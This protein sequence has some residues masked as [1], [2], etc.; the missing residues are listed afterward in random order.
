MKTS[1]NELIERLVNLSNAN[2]LN[3]KKSDCDIIDKIKDIVRNEFLEKEKKQIIDAFTKGNREEFYDG[4][5][6]LGFNYFN[7]TFKQ[8]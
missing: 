1:C 4:S 5:E 6:E 8:E 7:E 3:G 2:Y